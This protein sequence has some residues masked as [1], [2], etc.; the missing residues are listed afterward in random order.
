M[1]GCNPSPLH[2]P[3][4]SGPR[5]SSPVHP[6]HGAAEDRCDQS[7]RGP[8]QHAVVFHA[9]SS[10]LV[11][12]PFDPWRSRR[13]RDAAD[14]PSIPRGQVGARTRQLPCVRRHYLQPSHHVRRGGRILEV[15][16]SRLRRRVSCSRSC[17]SWR[18]HRVRGTNESIVRRG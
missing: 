1:I 15:W 12:S 2:I 9:L 17:Q 16:N 6:P 10:C 5:Y 14:A 8:S 13:S 7:A 3:E 4:V 18:L 11:G